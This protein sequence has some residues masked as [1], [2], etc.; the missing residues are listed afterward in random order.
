MKI[1]RCWV[2]LILSIVTLVVCSLMGYLVCNTHWSHDYRSEPLVYR[3]L[4]YL[5]TGIGLAV[6]LI[7]M[8]FSMVVHVI[9]LWRKDN[10]KK[11]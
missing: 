5:F 9:S 7:V 6:G 1:T 8:F 10:N 4:V 2:Y 11:E 3:L